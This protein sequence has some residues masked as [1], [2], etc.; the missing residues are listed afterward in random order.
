MARLRSYLISSG[1]A[2]VI[3]ASG[4]PLVIAEGNPHY[5]RVLEALKT[6][7]HD[8]D[9]EALMSIT[10]A[11]ETLT[12]GKVR[13]DGRQL[14]VN[15]RQIEDPILL[16]FVLKMKDEGQPL[17]PFE[18]FMERLDR[19]PSMRS[20]KTLFGYIT[21]CGLTLDPEGFILAY[22][23]V[24]DDYRDFHTGKVD[25]SVGNTVKEDR[26]EIDDD[27]NS[28]CSFGLHV[29]GHEYVRGF[30]ENGRKLLVK[31]DPEHVV[32]IPYDA[33]CRKMRVCEA[34]VI[35][36]L[37]RDFFSKMEPIHTTVH[38]TV[39][40]EPVGGL[41]GV[42]VEGRGDAKLYVIVQAHSDEEAMAK[43]HDWFCDP[44]DF[45][46]DEIEYSRPD[47]FPVISSDFLVG[48]SEPDDVSAV[49]IQPGETAYEVLIYGEGRN[50]VERRNRA[51]VVWASSEEEARKKAVDDV[52]EG[53]TDTDPLENY[54]VVSV[55]PKLIFYSEVPLPVVGVQAPDGLI[56][57]S[58]IAN[59]TITAA[60]TV[61]GNVTTNVVS[62]SVDDEDMALVRDYLVKGKGF[63]GMP[64][65]KV[66]KAIT[67]EHARQRFLEAYPSMPLLASELSVTLV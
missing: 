20:R 37:N 48:Y 64:I 42:E 8:A 2:T 43:A 3:L 22:K 60:H 51:V 67:E 5:H 65:S 13:Y 7:G 46:L 1:S 44:D 31:V 55:N 11:V 61:I 63:M 54:E 18:L 26:R 16:D 41:Y 45:D 29:G 23:S 39:V 49:E 32:C 62:S 33:S 40:E 56:T 17:R 50:S 14:V 57:T 58:Q 4:R 47:D 36:E 35:A 10:S 25:W 59:G 19:N 6:Q 38:E 27:P 9:V 53:H 21:T 15:G 28:A 52:E 12:E 66:V 30:H 24:R 34:T